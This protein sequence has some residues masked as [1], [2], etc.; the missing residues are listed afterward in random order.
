MRDSFVFYRSFY[1]AIR[2]LPRDIQGEIYTAIMEYGLYGKETENLKPVARSIF[3]LVK[4]Q[5]DA[6]NVRFVNGSQGGAPKGNRNNPNGRKG[7]EKSAET[8]QEP[9][10]NQ[11]R[12]NQELTENQPNVNVNDNVNVNENDNEK[13]TLSSREQK[14]TAAS[15]GEREGNL[16]FLRQK[17]NDCAV[18]TGAHLSTEEIIADISSLSPLS[19]RLAKRFGLDDELLKRVTAE[20]FDTWRFEGYTN[21]RKG[22]RAYFANLVRRKADALRPEIEARASRQREQD[23]RIDESRRQQQHASQAVTWKAFASQNGMEGKSLAEVLAA[24]ARGSGE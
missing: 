22:A 16:G 18:A 2:E 6:N 9:T 13:K 14:K 8:N 20:I 3:L 10:E 5:I 4:P 12:T 15:G 24:S 17:G 21:T 11:P 19:R 7:K 1:E 23:R